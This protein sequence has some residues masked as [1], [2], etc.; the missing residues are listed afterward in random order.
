MTKQKQSFLAIITPF[1]RGIGQIMLQH[2]YLTGLLFLAGICC[3]SLM[4]GLAVTIA[5]ISVAL[6]V[7]IKIQM[8]H[9]HLPALTFPFV[10]ATWLAMVIKVAKQTVYIKLKQ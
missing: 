10:L 3:G 8:R 6:S 2:N 5:V 4:M 1:L 7:L 9:L